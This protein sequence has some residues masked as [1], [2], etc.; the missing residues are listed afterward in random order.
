MISSPQKRLTAY[1]SSHSV[2]YQF[3]LC[4]ATSELQAPVAPF[5]MTT[6]LCGRSPPHPDPRCEKKRRSDSV[7]WEITPGQW[8]SIRFIVDSDDGVHQHEEWVPGTVVRYYTGPGASA[9]WW[10]I[11][12]QDG[13]TVVRRL[14][15]TRVWKEAK[16]IN[17]PSPST[18]SHTTSSPFFPPL[19]DVDVQLD[20]ARGRRR[21]LMDNE[22]RPRYRG[23]IPGFL[24]TTHLWAV[25]ATAHVCIAAVYT[26]FDIWSVAPRVLFGV[27]TW[28]NVVFSDKLHNLD[29]NHLQERMTLDAEHVWW[30]YDL[31]VIS[32]VLTAQHCLWTYN[33][34]AQTYAGGYACA[35]N[36]LA[37][38][39]V[40]VVLACKTQSK[41]SRGAHENFCQVTF[42]L[43]FVACAELGWSCLA[44]PHCGYF[45][46][47]WFV[48]APGF[49]AFV[50]KSRLD[51]RRFI[52]FGPHEVF[53]VFCFL[54]HIV[55]MLIDIRHV[56][57]H[58][59]CRPLM[60][61]E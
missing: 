12:L 25:L 6:C 42:G 24:N 29:R 30:R 21:Y 31:F 37:T 49:A 11:L 13:S 61:L 55:S 59:L 45:T 14:D 43:Q 16:L 1:L 27:A 15:P 34:E 5:Q 44:A 23:T 57:G 19:E 20:R 2:T 28:L 3:H 17:P 22:P 50:S 39:A 46:S 35:F 52:R 36:A 54:G 26:H 51:E 41:T 4:H 53:H 56:T 7:E 58:D 38:I 47:I 33:M 40:A 9:W 18:A 10:H 32:L 60:V 8:V 48:Y